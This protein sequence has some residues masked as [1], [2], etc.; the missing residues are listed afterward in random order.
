MIAYNVSKSRTEWFF[1]QI[2]E[3]KRD[4]KGETIV[5]IESATSSSRNEAEEYT[6]ILL[7]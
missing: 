3:T 1:I 5:R 7:L 2:E 6:H 4:G